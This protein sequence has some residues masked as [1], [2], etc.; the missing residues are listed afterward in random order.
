MDNFFFD[1]V[2]EKTCIFTS[3][4]I[5]ILEKIF[6]VTFDNILKV[7]FFSRDTKKEYYEIL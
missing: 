4:K 3:Q 1:A 7:V 5:S 6:I 2:I